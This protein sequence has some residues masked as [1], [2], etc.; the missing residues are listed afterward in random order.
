MGGAADS[1]GFELDHLGDRLGQ[2]FVEAGAFAEKIA[3][4]DPELFV[5]RI[6]KT[7]TYLTH[8]GY[9]HPLVLDGSAR[10]WHGQALAWV[11]RALL[12]GELGFAAEEVASR[13][14]RTPRFQ[15]FQAGMKEEA[16]DGPAP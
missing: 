11:V 4:A 2:L 9:R 14:E 15:A 7:R 5:R 16:A 1:E 6:I 13:I 10:F 12:L 3:G 8:R